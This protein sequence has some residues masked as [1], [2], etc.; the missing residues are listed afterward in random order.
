MS[1][2]HIEYPD[3][4]DVSLQHN[5][6]N[7]LAEPSHVNALRIDVARTLYTTPS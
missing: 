2:V 7:S 6:K 1:E 4:H 5:N 3:L